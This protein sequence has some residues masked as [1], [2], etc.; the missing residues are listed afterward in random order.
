MRLVLSALGRTDDRQPHRRSSEPAS[1]SFVVSEGNLALNFENFVKEKEK[2]GEDIV[3]SE[4]L[5]REP[6]MSNLLIGSGPL[7]SELVV[8]RPDPR[9]SPPPNP[10]LAP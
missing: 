4:P 1:E 8:A 2:D 10:S 3:G 7:M 5:N 9:G 6:L